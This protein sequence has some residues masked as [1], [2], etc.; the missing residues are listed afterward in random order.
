MAE[1]AILATRVDTSLSTVD[2]QCSQLSRIARDAHFTHTRIEL[3]TTHLPDYYQSLMYGV[4]RRVTATGQNEN[5][6]VVPT[7]L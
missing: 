2:S 1:T 3:H 5:F 6:R 4:A 7:V